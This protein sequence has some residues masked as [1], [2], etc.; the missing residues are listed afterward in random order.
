MKNKQVAQLLYEVAEILEI[1]EIPFKPRAYE[2]A[3]MAV[4][5]LSEDITNIAKRGDLQKIQGV[6]KGIEEAILEIIKTGKLK[7]L[8]KLRKQAPMDIKGLSRIEGLGPK[9]IKIL[10]KKLKI[11]TV[12]DLKKAA[13][14]GKIS[15]LKGFGKTVEN[16]I[17]KG[18]AFT[19]ISKGRMLLGLAY[20]IA[21]ELVN[22]IKK[23]KLATKVEIA[24]SLRRRKETV[25]D[26]DILTC[27]K[28][29]KQLMEY[30]LDLSQIKRIIAKGPTKA[31]VVLQEG[32]RCDLRVLDD[33]SW[34]SGQQYFIGSKQHNVELRKIAIKKGYKLSE[35]GLFKGKKQI[36]G[37]RESDIY[38][39]LGMQWIPPAIRE[40][41]GEIETAMKKKISR[42]IQ[43]KD[44]QGDLHSHTKASDGSNTI[45]EMAQ[46]AKQA[47]LK[48]LN[49]SDHSGIL[50]I[51]GA[52]SEKQLIKHI[53]EID[54][55][56]KKIKNFTIL[57][58][59]E[60]DIKE[61]GDL[62]ISNKTLKKLDVVLASIHTGFK[63]PK[64]TQR[65]ITA[66]ENPYVHI[67]AHPTGRL[68]KQR[69]AYKIDF[70]KICQAAKDTHTA[71]EIDSSPKRLDLHA[72]HIR[73]AI[74]HKIKLVIN[75]DAHS[76]RHFDFLKYGVFTAQRG[77]AQKKHILNTLPLQKFLKKLK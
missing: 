42:L 12:T 63:Q 68:I 60:V 2:R 17:L 31:T 13:K 6:G 38:K 45:L 4:E 75:S 15:K 19:K 69:E 39:K 62:A 46:A 43:E 55:A 57:K 30:F 32:I 58:G 65:I 49:I 26:I 70:N 48:Y 71:L 22:E 77:W 5:S 59:A 7:L 24:G 40:N 10:Y 73:I 27:S 33:K 56:N 16:N 18:I 11:R 47:G 37:E 34:G 9:S 64:M 21:Q 20:P 29:K 3:A 52:L 1:Q 35:Y 74:D 41:E 51:A 28:K 61:K 76:V 14:A 53:K 54:K 72:N 44:L 8:I 25:G 67:F 66:M 23:S 50:K 36:A